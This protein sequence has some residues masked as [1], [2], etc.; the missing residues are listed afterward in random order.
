MQGADV[1]VGLVLVV[2]RALHE[3]LVGAPLV[4][5]QIGVLSPCAAGR[6][7]GAA[8]AWRVGTIFRTVEHGAS[9]GFD[10]FAHTGVALVARKAD[11]A[12]ATGGRH[13]L[14]AKDTLVVGRAAGALGVGEGEQGEEGEGDEGG[15]SGC[16]CVGKVAIVLVSG[17]D[18]GGVVA[19]EFERSR[20][21]LLKRSWGGSK[22]GARSTRVH[23]HKRSASE[24][25]MAHHQ[26]RR[27]CWLCVASALQIGVLIR[28]RGMEAAADGANHHGPSQKGPATE[29]RI[30]P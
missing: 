16:H 23:R 12:V 7:A 11:D 13:A 18:E 9:L 10:G 15:S 27:V 8:V 3:A 14:A 5:L 6:L 19:G 26:R 21:R 28:V 4:A 29:F 25:E 24:H 2:Q 30:W 20:T 17:R 22:P 1:A